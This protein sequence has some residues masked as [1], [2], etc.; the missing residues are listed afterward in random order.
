MQKIHCHSSV[1][2]LHSM[3]GM[4]DTVLNLVLPDESVQG[5]LSRLATSV[6]PL[7]GT[8]TVVLCPDVLWR[9]YG[10]LLE[11]FEDAI[12]AKKVEKGVKLDT[13]LTQMTFVTL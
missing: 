8:L 11:F 4:M 13:E 1:P 9:C 12:A 3:P 5:P 2:V 6:F 7:L 10:R